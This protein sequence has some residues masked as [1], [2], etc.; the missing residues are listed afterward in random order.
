[1]SEE[2]CNRLFQNFVQADNSTQRQFGGTG[3]GL[4]ISKKLVELMNGEIGV[5]SV[6]GEGS[7]FW[8]EIPT[9]EVSTDGSTVELPSLDGLSVLSVEDHPQGAKEIVNSLRSMGANIESCPTY[10][11]GPKKRPG[12]KEG[13]TPKMVRK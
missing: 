1:M 11:E 12:G 10:K 8:F 5:H 6:E 9:R 4:S 3:L 7:T 13:A 2:V